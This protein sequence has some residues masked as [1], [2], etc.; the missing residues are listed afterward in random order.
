MVEFVLRQVDRGEADP[1]HPNLSR[2]GRYLRLIES[3]SSFTLLWQS[4][5]SETDSISWYHKACLSQ[6]T[7]PKVLLFLITIFLSGEKRS[8]ILT[9]HFCPSCV[10]FHSV[11]TGVRVPKA[12]EVSALLSS[13][14]VDYCLLVFILPTFSL[15]FH[16]HK[17]QRMLMSLVLCSYSSHHQSIITVKKLSSKCSWTMSLFTA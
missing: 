10:F 3:L 1:L 8:C 5:T 16:Y 7:L 11:P 12:W 15:G 4:T 17:S 13:L 2:F 14:N 9:W 6:C